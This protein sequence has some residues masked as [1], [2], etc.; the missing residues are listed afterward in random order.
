MAREFI[1]ADNHQF[2]FSRTLLERSVERARAREKGLHDR[3][4]CVRGAERLKLSPGDRA[5]RG[6]GVGGFV[7]GA[8]AGRDPLCDRGLYAE[9][10]F[11]TN[12]ELELLLAPDHPMNPT[13]YASFSFSGCPGALSS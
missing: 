2:L 7:R 9:R 13:V 4:V 8:L 6:V 10:R 5:G 3:V 11:W 1:N 12:R